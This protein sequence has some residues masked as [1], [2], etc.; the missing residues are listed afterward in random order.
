[1]FMGWHPASFVRCALAALATAMAAPLSAQD[2]RDVPEQAPELADGLTVGFTEQISPYVLVD[3]TDRIGGVRA[4]LWQL[5]SHETGIPVTLLHVPPESLRDAV[6][7][8]RIDVIDMTAPGGGRD[9]FLDFSPQYAEVALALFHRTDMARLVDLD[10]LRGRLVGVTQRSTCEDRLAARG[11]RLQVYPTLQDLGAAAR[12]G[13][14]PAIFCL[15][16]TM[17]DTLFSSLGIGTRYT[18]TAPIIVTTG[19]WAVGKGRSDLYHAV[20]AGLAAIPHEDQTALTERWSGDNLSALLGYSSRDILRL[21]QTLAL[22]VAVGIVTAVILRWR[23]GRALAARAAT[24]DALR[25]RIREQS[26]LHDV[27]LATEDMTRPRADMLADIAA[28]LSRGCGDGGQTRFRIRLYDTVHDAIPAGQD[29]A[30][31]L[32]VMIEGRQQGE[33]AVHCTAPHGPVT[34]EARLLIELAAS[35]LAGRCLGAMASQRLVQSEERFRRT[36]KHSA[37]ATAVIQNGIFTE[38][39]TAALAMLGYSDGQGFV[40]LRPDE[41]SPEYQPDGQRSRDKAALL[42]AEALEGG[43]VKFDWEHLRADGTPV[44]IEVLLTAVADDDRIDV[45]TLWNDVTVKRQAEAALAAYQRTLEEQVAQRTAELTA[46]N[47]ELQAIL[48]TADSGICLVRDRVLLTC[49]RALSQLLMRPVDQ[50]VGASTRILFK[51]DADWMDGVEDAYAAIASGQ[52]FTATR[53]LIRGDGSTVWV[54][55]RATAIDLTD[56]AR[57]TVWVMQDISNDRAAAQKL[58]NARDM[59]EQAARLKSEFLAHMSHELRSPLNAILGFTELLIGTPLTPHQI[60]HL[61]KVQAAG[62]HLLMIVNDV[63]D[64]SKVEAGKLRIERTEF[65]LAQVIKAAVDTVA[66]AAADKDIE[67]IVE[68]DPRLPARFTGDPLRITQILM[69]YLTNA[70]KFT[71]TGEI[72]LSV[73]QRDAGRV[74]FCV[75]DTGIGMSP[76]QVARMFQSFSQAEDSTARLYGGTGLGLSICR[77]LA[78]LMDGEVGVESTPG[79]GSTFWV[80]LPLPAAPATGGPRR[81]PPMRGRRLLVVD[82]NARAAAATA[83]LLRYAGAEA[84]TAPSG[85]A[86]L[87]AASAARQDGQPFDV[88]LIDRSM[89]DPDGIATARLLRESMGMAVPPLL[90]MSRRGGQDAV[91]TAFREGFD[92]VVTKPVERELLVDRLASLVRPRPARRG[93]PVRE[94]AASVPPK[95]PAAT[96]AL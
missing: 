21:I 64:L 93:T 54:S 63:L 58:A 75:S 78:G 42:I 85:S 80:D 16:V 48:A 86:A 19:H 37:Q 23:L 32:P 20:E 30:L 34:A 10:D 90:L 39:N 95:A 92:D 40:G 13:G 79:T 83:A 68:S 56:P 74:R 84:V 4:E 73:T 41:I 94:P 14:G 67:L 89:P 31:A 22:M 26:C 51:S 9:A 52:T 55:L 53:E 57:G 45:F 47:D 17:G 96:P 38:A 77:Q 66:A 61:R 46:L 87:A 2:I 8:G 18:H 88:I 3:P 35:R 1:M 44:L 82:D 70:L 12:D 50:L 91:D 33:I 29:P 59:A 76:E 81:A 11:V 72:V 60:D 49:N 69:N 25:Q 7:Q 6:E 62:R 28:A 15:P 43:N 24:A 71:Q 5:W 27:F 65:P 36:F